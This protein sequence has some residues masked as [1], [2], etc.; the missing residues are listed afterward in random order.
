M[1]ISEDTM[2]MK[3]I[4]VKAEDMLKKAG[5]P[6]SRLTVVWI[7]CDVL[8]CEPAHLI[9]HEDML[10]KRDQIVRILAMT[11]RCAAH[12]PVQYVT[13][14]TEFY[15]MHLYVSPEVL[16]PRP[17][18]EQLVELA[19]SLVQAME[20]RRILDIGTGSGAIA[21]AMKQSIPDAHV[22]ACDIST[23]ALCIA[24]ENAE[25]N[26][27][28]IH[29]VQ[30]D[31]LAQDFTDI[32][33]NGYDLVI[34]NPPYIPDS[35][36]SELPRMV[37]EH[38]PAAALFCGEDPHQFYRAI[39]DHT[40]RGLLHP[41]GILALETHTDYTDSVAMMLRQRTALQVEVEKDLSEL[42]RFVIAQSCQQ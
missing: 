21:L 3:E 30:A 5:I 39:A 41:S 25:Q 23:D 27:Q 9:V 14:H 42:P 32:A 24:Q 28:E 20:T 18:T 17:E 15:G 11:E 2:N 31:M 1:E 33:G 12:E 29:L 16:I 36:H 4:F 6:E 8:D 13:G 19:L 40:G 22:T 37:R 7:F 35:E 34:A 26:E 10:L 38:E